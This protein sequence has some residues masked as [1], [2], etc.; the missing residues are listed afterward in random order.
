M[1]PVREKAYTRAAA[2]RR[3]SGA[4]CSPHSPRLHATATGGPR[5]ELVCI[6]AGR[7]ILQ[8]IVRLLPRGPETMVTATRPT[9]ACM[10]LLR[11]APHPLIARAA[12]YLLRRL[13]A[14]DAAEL[15][16]VD[17]LAETAPGLQGRALPFQA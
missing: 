17:V 15:A 10:A 8:R 2:R 1:A 12:F 4:R 3:A 14:I 11:G 5:L 9:A 7:D 6:Q 16:T 13:V